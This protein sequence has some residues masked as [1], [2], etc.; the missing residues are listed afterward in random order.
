MHTLLRSLIY[1]TND[2]GNAST[3]EGSTGD[4]PVDG[5]HCIDLQNE[6]TPH[7]TVPAEENPR[8]EPEATP[9]ILHRKRNGYWHVDVIGESLN[10]FNYYTSFRDLIK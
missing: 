7:G 10:S 4:P 1:N 6:A 5:G 8:I 2:A 9:P 3:H